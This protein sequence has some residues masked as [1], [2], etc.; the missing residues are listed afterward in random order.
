VQYIATLLQLRREVLIESGYEVVSAMRVHV[1]L[2]LLDHQRFDAVVVGHAV[3]I[4]HKKA[5]VDT[6]AQ[7][8]TPVLLLYEGKP[9]PIIAAG[10]VDGLR[11]PEQMGD[12][13]KAILASAAKKC[14][15]K[16]TAPAHK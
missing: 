13:I 11:G 14:V 6:A 7:T 5:I 12:G 1:A 3:P 8:N 16:Q 10:H 9:D 15:R 2:G 4:R